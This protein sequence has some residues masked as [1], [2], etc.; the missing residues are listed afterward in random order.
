MSKQDRPSQHARLV[1][2]RCV[3]D[4]RDLIGDGWAHIS[5]DLRW[6]LVCT[7][8]LS[9]IV[10]Q[11]ALEDEAATIE[12]RAHVADYALALWRS[13]YEIRDNDWKRVG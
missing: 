2:W 6:G 8:I 11:H 13:A 7:N 1:A 10:R 3:R 12:E 9:V 4:A 5:D